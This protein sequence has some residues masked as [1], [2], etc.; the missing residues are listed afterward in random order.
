MQ[1][2]ARK[3]RDTVIITET[4]KNEI[5]ANIQRA[6]NRK[7]QVQIEADLHEIPLSTVKEIMKE[8][9]LSLRLLNGGRREPKKPAE[10]AAKQ[11]IPDNELPDVVQEAIRKE[12]EAA[13]DW[14]DLAIPPLEGPILTDV[15]DIP[16]KEIK[17]KMEPLDGLP[18]GI[19]EDNPGE[20]W[21][22]ADREGSE[23]RE[24]QDYI[25]ELPA[26]LMEVNKKRQAI[27]KKMEK[28]DGLEASILHHCI[29]IYN[30]AKEA[31]EL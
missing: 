5:V 18:I 3:R 17:C 6:K 31:E 1:L 10:Q 22:S 19:G 20:S 12:T 11:W 25:E 23:P 24:L 28:A 4:M 9:G 26:I 14:A 15:Q 29:A 8:K 30:I 2:T 7:K 21:T 13:Q 27:L 16:H